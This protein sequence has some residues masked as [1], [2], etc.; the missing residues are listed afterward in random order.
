MTV[1]EEKLFQVGDLLAQLDTYVGIGYQHP[2]VRHLY[3]LCGALDV[4]TSLDGIL[5][6]CEWLVLNELET[7]GVIDQGITGDTGLVVIG[8][9]ETTIDD[10]QLAICLDRVLTLGRS[11]R[12]VTI[13]DMTV[14]ARHPKGIHDVVDDLLAVS[15]L[16]V[17]ALFLLVRLLVGDEVTLEGSH[18]ALVEEWTVG[19]TPEI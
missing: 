9:R 11:H 7:T 15:Q 2:A 1:G 3:D 6:A 12:Y 13:D 14:G 19:T 8:F 17:I 10:H 16:E 4:G 18:L 5:S